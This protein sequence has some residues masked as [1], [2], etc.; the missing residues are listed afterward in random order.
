GGV[1]RVHILPWAQDGALLGE[2]YTHA[3]VGTMVTEEDMACVRP[4]AA[5]DVGG[6][7]RLLAIFEADGTLVPRSREK[8]ER[9]IEHFTVLEHD[10]VIYGS[11]EL[12][13]YPAEGAAE[14]AAVAVHPAHQGAGDGDKLLRAIEHKARALGIGRLFVLTTRTEHWFVSRGFAPAGVEDLPEAKRSSYNWSRRS[15]IFVK[16]L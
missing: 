5:E 11:A 16:N 1:E 12:I 10:G 4:A 15:K 13:P 6:L 7:L 8:V 14:M 9:E 3:G 2:L